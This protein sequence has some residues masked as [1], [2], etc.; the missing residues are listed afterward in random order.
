MEILWNHGSAGEEIK[1]CKFLFQLSALLFQAQPQLNL[2][3]SWIIQMLNNLWMQ[4][5]QRAGDGDAALL[6][7]WSC[8]GLEPS[9]KHHQVITEDILKGDW[10]GTWTT[11]ASPVW[12]SLLA[13]MRQTLPSLSS[14]RLIRELTLSS[15]QRIC[16]GDG[17]AWYKKRG[18]QMLISPFL[19]C[20]G[21]FNLYVPP[22]SCAGSAVN[23]KASRLIT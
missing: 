23:K 19:K 11:V 18:K 14:P 2:H 21:N 8:W 9:L 12:C 17:G 4:Q 16:W 6:S 15:C 10:R 1:K 7:L 13:N 3:Q 22:A 20:R 5:F